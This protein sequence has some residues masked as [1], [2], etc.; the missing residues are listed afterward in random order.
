MYLRSNRFLAAAVFL[1]AM[2]AVAQ[3]NPT[4]PASP[5]PSATATKTWPTVDGTVVLDNFRFGT[6][7]TLPQLKLHYLTLGTPHRKC[8]RAY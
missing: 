1:S 6:G 2:T 8:R 3:T 4:M 7:E 5:A